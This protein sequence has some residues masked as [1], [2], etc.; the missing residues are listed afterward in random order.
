M[1]LAIENSNIAL[2][3]DY[4]NTKLF[5]ME[6]THM[7]S[8]SVGRPTAFIAN[9]HKGSKPPHLFF[10]FISIKHLFFF[11]HGYIHTHKEKKCFICEGPRKAQQCPRFCSTTEGDQLMLWHRRVGHLCMRNLK[12]LRN[13]MATGVNFPNTTSTL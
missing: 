2:T 7:A 8:S 6:D 3:T 10:L 4:V 9:K 13:K 12:L 11:L 1:R 5:Q